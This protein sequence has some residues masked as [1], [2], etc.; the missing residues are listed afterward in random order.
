MSNRLTLSQLIGPPQSDMHDSK[1]LRLTE[2]KVVC[3]DCL[4]TQ[5]RG[6]TFTQQRLE[7]MQKSGMFDD[8]KSGVDRNH[9]Y[10]VYLTG[11][12]VE[13]LKKTW[14]SALV[15]DAEGT[16]ALLKAVSEEMKKELIR[17]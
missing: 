1:S 5:L 16:D 10:Y 7:E 13:L 8:N 4:L 9:C 12:V 11:K 14:G 17:N 6:G 15:V 2:D 3:I